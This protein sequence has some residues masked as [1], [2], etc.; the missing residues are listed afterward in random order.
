MVS[1]RDT[2][3][4]TGGCGFCNG[5]GTTLRGGIEKYFPWYP[6]NG[7]STIMRVI[8]G[9]ISP[10]RALFGARDVEGV[11]F[12]ERRGFAGAKFGATVA[13]QVQSRDALCNTGGM[14][15]WRSNQSHPRA[16]TNALGALTGGS[17]KTLRR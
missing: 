5:F 6:R 1:W 12:R 9:S 15:V 4:Q 2:A 13:H 16:E 14:I 10:H 17:Q 11:Q 7:V 3:I 8:T